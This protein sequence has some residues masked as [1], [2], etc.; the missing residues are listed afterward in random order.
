MKPLIDAIIIEPCDTGVVIV[1]PLL[2]AIANCSITQYCS[3]YSIA[4]TLIY[5]YGD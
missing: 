4:V 3:Y 2:C 1:F 5:Y